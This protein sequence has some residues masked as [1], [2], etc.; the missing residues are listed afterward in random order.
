MLFFEHSTAFLIRGLGLPTW[1]SNQLNHSKEKPWFFFRADKNSTKSI[2]SLSDMAKCRPSGISE[3]FILLARLA[4]SDFFLL[5]QSS[6]HSNGQSLIA[7]GYNSSEDGTLLGL[8]RPALVIETNACIWFYY[9]QQQLTL[10]QLVPDFGQPRAKVDPEISCLVARKAKLLENG[11]APLGVSNPGC[12][13]LDIFRR[14]KNSGSVL[15]DGGGG[16][17]DRLV[18]L[19]QLFSSRCLLQ[20]R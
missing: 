17:V 6:C 19:E 5:A 13:S 4:T 8:N 2:N 10:G 15:D 20:N 18:F 1:Q 16:L 3:I 12:K 11:F 7:L 9:G 14:G